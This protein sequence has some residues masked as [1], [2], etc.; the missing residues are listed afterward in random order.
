MSF[1]FRLNSLRVWAL[2]LSITVT[3][4]DFGRSYGIII[5]LLCFN[6]CVSWDIK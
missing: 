5:D 6:F 4:M 1:T 3:P 2:P